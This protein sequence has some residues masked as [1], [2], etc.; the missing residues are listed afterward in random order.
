MGNTDQM[1][2]LPETF[3]SI[4]NQTPQLQ[5]L[6]AVIRE[7]AAGTR[8]ALGEDRL[9]WLR[10][11]PLVQIHAPIALVHASPEDPWHAPTSNSNEDEYALSTN[12]SASRLWCTA[13]FISPTSASFHA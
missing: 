9:T 4:A 6:W 1:L 7:M 12:H 13:I 10:N 5:S 3:E 2:A 8:E 11:L